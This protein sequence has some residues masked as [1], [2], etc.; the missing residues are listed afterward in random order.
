MPGLPQHSA[1]PSPTPA[2]LATVR[3][4]RGLSIL[5]SWFALPI[6]LIKSSEERFEIRRSDGQLL[7]VFAGKEVHQPVRRP[8]EHTA[9][10]GGFALG[11]FQICG[12]LQIPRLRF[13]SPTDRNLMS[14]PFAQSR[15][16]LVRHEFP[17]PD[18]GN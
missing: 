4:K 10:F 7:D 8:F 18:N 13:I 5:G 9:P 16:G 1:A 6:A 17:V 14:G 11:E 15:K 2:S 3:E 12:R